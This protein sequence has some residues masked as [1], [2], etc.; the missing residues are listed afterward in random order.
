MWWEEAEKYKVLPL[1]GSMTARLAAE[2]PQTSKPRTQ[3]VY[4]PNASVVPAFAAPPLYNR[5][6]S[7]EVDAEVTNGSTG[8]LVAQGGDAG[9]Y[10]LFVHDGRL[11]FDYNYVGRDQFHL[12]GSEPLTE[13]RHALRF[14]FEP[15]GVP[16]FTTGK[17]VAGRGQLYVDS[18]LIASEEFP[19]TTPLLFG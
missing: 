16:D 5:A 18:T 7:I 17:G 13:G 12:V 19:H 2:R 3:Y 6:Y 4:Y 8:V 9:G 11:K 14:E 15:I 1:D 10:S